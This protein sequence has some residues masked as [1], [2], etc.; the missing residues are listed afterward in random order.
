MDKIE[1]ITHYTLCRELD[2]IDGHPVV[3]EWK[4]FP[5][6]TTLKLLTEV[7]N[8]MEKELNVLSQDFKDPIISMSM[9]NDIDWSQLTESS[10]IG[11]TNL[12]SESKLILHK[13]RGHILRKWIVI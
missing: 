11:T 3:F 6:H 13:A 1:W 2:R 4:I 9:F 10:R 5:G 7:Q 12:L 8:M